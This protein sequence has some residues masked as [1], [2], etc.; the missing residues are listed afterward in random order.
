M[1]IFE[2]VMTIIGVPILLFLVGLAGAIGDDD[3]FPDNDNGI[4]G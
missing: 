2:I 3:D 4:Q 1:S